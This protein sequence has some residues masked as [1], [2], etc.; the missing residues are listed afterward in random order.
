MHLCLC[1][2]VSMGVNSFLH[3]INNFAFSIKFWDDFSLVKGDPIEAGTPYSASCSTMRGRAG[4]I[5]W[6]PVLEI[7]LV[8]GTN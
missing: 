6:D 2:R 7:D 8:P 3:F 1:L 4:G 5:K